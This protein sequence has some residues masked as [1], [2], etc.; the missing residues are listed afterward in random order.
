MFREYLWA[1]RTTTEITVIRKNKIAE[2]SELLK[3]T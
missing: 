1:R 2:D 3:E